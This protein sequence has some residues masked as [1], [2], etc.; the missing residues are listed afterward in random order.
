MN[1]YPPGCR[2]WWSSPPSPVTCSSSAR[3]TSSA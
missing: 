3:S 2:P 1:T